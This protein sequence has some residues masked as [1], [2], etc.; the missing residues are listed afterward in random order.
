MRR[1]YLTP[2]RKES[3]HQCFSAMDDD[4][5]DE[6]DSSYKADSENSEYSD[7]CSSDLEGNTRECD[8]GLLFNHPPLPRPLLPFINRN[9]K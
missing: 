7:S 3:A 4:E 1:I 5:E 2:P 9:I 6:Y 8:I